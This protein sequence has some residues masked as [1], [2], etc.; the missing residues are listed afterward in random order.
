MSALESRKAFTGLG[1]FGL[2]LKDAQKFQRQAKGGS[3]ISLILSFIHK[4]LFWWRGGERSPIR[5][6]KDQ[7]GIPERERVN[8]GQRIPKFTVRMNPQGI[9]LKCRF[10]I[11]RSGVGVSNKLPSDAPDSGSWTTLYVARV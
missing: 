9:L 6:N 7:V 8:L 3:G 5:E 4:E 1:P 2:A 10:R 11:R